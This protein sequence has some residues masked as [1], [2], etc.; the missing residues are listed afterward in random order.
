MEYAYFA[1][2]RAFAYS[3]PN[4]T[5]ILPPL[6][7]IDERGHVCHDGDGLAEV[8][9]VAVVLLGAL[10]DSIFVD[11]VSIVDIKKDIVKLP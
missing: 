5:D 9:L 1:Y 10:E 3:S 6:G 7:L 8:F 11:I 2:K 4:L